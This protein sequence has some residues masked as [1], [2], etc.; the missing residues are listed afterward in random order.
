LLECPEAPDTTEA[1]VFCQGDAR[2]SGRSKFVYCIHDRSNHDAFTRAVEKA[3][4]SAEFIP[5]TINGAAVPAYLSF[6]VHFRREPE[7]CEFTPF[8]TLVTMTR[9]SVLNWV[10]PQEVRIRPNW[11]TPRV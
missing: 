2:K 3:S 8:R 7:G 4:M 5:A 10:A 1:T 11:V 6:R 9:S